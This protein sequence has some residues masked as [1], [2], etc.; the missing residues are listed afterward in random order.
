VSLAKDRPTWFV[1]TRSS[2]GSL[3]RTALEK[4]AWIERTFLSGW[5]A[6]EATIDWASTW[7]PNTT[8]R[9]SGSPTL[10]TE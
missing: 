5:W 3:T 9:A 6:E 8:S 4:T 1:S 10:T 2:I 7:P